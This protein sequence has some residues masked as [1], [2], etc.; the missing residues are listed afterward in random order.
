MQCFQRCNEFYTG[1]GE[2]RQ[3]V[4][5]HAEAQLLSILQK[6]IQYLALP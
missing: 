3:L 4:Q 6:Q 2:K 1:S 5:I